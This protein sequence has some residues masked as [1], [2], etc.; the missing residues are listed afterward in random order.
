M[1]QKQH[2]CVNILKIVAE[3]F[4]DLRITVLD[5]FAEH[6]MV[7]TRVRYE[8]SHTGLCMEFPQ[9]GNIFILKPW[10]ISEF[11]MGKMWNPGAIGRNG[12]L[13]RIC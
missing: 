11:P 6:D 2:R 3:Q 10:K 12:R 13:K 5:I 4:S 9:R 1:S 7:A 8:G